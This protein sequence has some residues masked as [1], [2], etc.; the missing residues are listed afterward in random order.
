MAARLPLVGS[1][2]L[3]KTNMKIKTSYHNLKENVGGVLLGLG[4][5][6]V[7]SIGIKWILAL[8]L[9]PVLFLLTFLGVNTS[10]IPENLENRIAILAYIL[11]VGYIFLGEKISKFIIKKQ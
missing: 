4:L 7:I 11:A 6:L 5:A 3:L 9:I 10:F 8:L 2:L 1:F